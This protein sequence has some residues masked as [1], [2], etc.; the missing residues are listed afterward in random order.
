[1]VSGSCKTI[2]CQCRKTVLKEKPFLIMS[3]LNNQSSFSMDRARAAFSKQNNQRERTAY[4]PFYR[5]PEGKSSTLRFIPD[6]DPD[7]EMGFIKARKTHEFIVEGEKVRV[8]CLSNYGDDCPMCNL[9]RQ[10]Y[11]AKD[12]VNGKVF[13][14]KQDWFARAL[15]VKDGLPPDPD[16][17]ETYMGQVVNLSLGKTIYE[18]IAHNISSGML[19]DELPCHVSEG[20]DFIITRTTKPGPDGEKYSDYSLSQFARK[21]RPLEDEEIAII[22]REEED[23]STPNYVELKSLMPKKPTLEYVEQIMET[24]LEELGAAPVA[25]PRARPQRDEEEAP[26]ARPAVPAARPAAR[27]PANESAPA[28]RPAARP[29]PAPA[30]DSEADDGE[31]FLR[32][33]R[34]RRAASAPAPVAPPARASSGFDDMDDD[35]PF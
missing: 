10:Y 30:A 35:I 14:P 29:A 7:N 4:Y 1:M 33:I 27:A 32:E 5:L 9:S 17:G 24:V 3:K 22:E 31:A 13:W 23:G 12:K 20:T 18:L 8:S 6:A 19:G 21:S 34:A 28:A 16:T 25:S 26:R 15:V 2:G 11:K